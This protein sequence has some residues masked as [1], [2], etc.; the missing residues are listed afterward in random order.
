LPPEKVIA[1]LRSERG[2]GLWPDAVDA[3]EQVL[4]SIREGIG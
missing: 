1:I 4:G 2:I 3:A